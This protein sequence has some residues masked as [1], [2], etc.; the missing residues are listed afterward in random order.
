MLLSPP[1]T[2]HGGAPM[3]V[4][5]RPKKK[6]SKFESLRPILNML[7]NFLMGHGVVRQKAATV[8]LGEMG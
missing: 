8:V 3:D 6:M 1:L 7:E 4:E 2:M 5:L